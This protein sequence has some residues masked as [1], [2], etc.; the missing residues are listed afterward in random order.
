MNKR[1]KGT[2]FEELACNY[3]KEN[4][5]TILFRNF[6]CRSGEI[7]IIAKDGRYISF[8]EVKYRTGAKYGVAEAAVDLRKQRT[9]CRVSDFFR[10]QNKITADAAQRFDVVAMMQED[11][12]TVHIK[13]HK[14]AFSYI[15][16]NKASY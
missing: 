14:N 11:D 6:R 7:D 2:Y 4:G 8:I 15:P 12:G 16:L 3:L 10:R 5:A 13:W 1:E 9:I